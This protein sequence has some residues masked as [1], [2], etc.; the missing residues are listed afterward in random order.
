MRPKRSDE[1]SH[2]ILDGTCVTCGA[3]EP[4]L[5]WAPCPV[6]AWDNGHR[7]NL[8]TRVCSLCGAEGFTLRAPCPHQWTPTT[9]WENVKAFVPPIATVLAVW[10]TWWTLA[11]EDVNSPDVVLPG[12]GAGAGAALALMVVGWLTERDRSG[13]VLTGVA[14]VLILAAFFGM[15]AFFLFVGWWVLPVLLLWGLWRTARRPWNA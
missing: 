4:A 5:L 2:A 12:L 14:L 9:T 11:P 1:G 7:P 3:S 8:W 6:S 13:P 15:V 10:W